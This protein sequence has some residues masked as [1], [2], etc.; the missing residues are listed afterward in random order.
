MPM[1]LV[2]FAVAAFNH[3]KF[4]KEALESVWNDGYPRKQI[5]IIDDGSTDNTANIIND[6]CATKGRNEVIFQSGPNLGITAT[7]NRL[8]SLSKGEYIRLMSSDDVLLPGGTKKMVDL[9][10][11]DQNAIAAFGDSLLID[12]NGDIISNST[13]EFNGADKKKYL[14]QSQLTESI[15]S[16]WAV[17]GPVILIRRD[18]Y[19]E[20]GAYDASLMVDDWDLYLRVTSLNG[21]RFVDD[22]VAKYRVHGANTSRTLDIGKRV[23]NLKSQMTVAEKNIKIFSSNQQINLLRAEYYLLG[24]KIDYL[25]KRWVRCGLNL[26]WFLKFRHKKILRKKSE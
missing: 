14:D 13:L 16:K 20:N 6:W 1:K 7:L 4:V 23:L 15:I 2:T 24:A 26:L 22:V 17:S 5:V 11:R 21:L 9:L 19:V 18:F 3:G 25:S 8:I 12:G 10:N